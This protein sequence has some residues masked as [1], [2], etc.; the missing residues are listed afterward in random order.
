MSSSQPP[1]EK[2]HKKDKKDKK[3]KKRAKEEARRLALSHSKPQ[4]S[5]SFSSYKYSILGHHFLIASIS[6]CIHLRTATAASFSNLAMLMFL[7][8]QD[9]APPV[10]L[11]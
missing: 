11:S 5:G 2:K 6:K 4:C 10:T 7:G 3:E 9:A 1:Q 8:L